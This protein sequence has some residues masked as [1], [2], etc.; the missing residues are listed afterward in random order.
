V[1][2][3][4][5]VRIGDAIMDK[6]RRRLLTGLGTLA[7]GSG[8]TLTAGSFNNSTQSASDMRVVVA[9][10]LEVRAGQAF[11]NDGT[12][13][14]NH[15]DSNGNPNNFVKYAS[16]SS[17]FDAGPSGG[18]EDID[19][20]DLPVATVNRRDQNVN[21]DVKIQV[22]TDVDTTSVTF[23]DIL[24]IV[25][26]GTDSVKVGISYDRDDN[27]YGDDVNVGG[28]PQ[29]D[30]TQ[31]T[32]QHVY[33]FIGHGDGTFGSGRISPNQ[34]SQNDDPA[35][36]AQI[37]PGGTIPIDLKID[38]SDMF[39]YI[40]VKDNIKDHANPTGNPFQGRV[41]TVDMLDELTVGVED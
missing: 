19:T 8:A 37:D 6:R 9:E 23:H 14:S 40:N 15:P 18:L 31:Q 17:F 22:A 2:L 10:N 21:E 29:S 30:I 1:D 3:S 5:A 16:N 36:V 27:Q 41:D 34:S 4:I 20:D 24:E 35:N 13:K 7:F 25:N 28:S 26:N 12:I 33:R 11:N 38:L 32:V 39:D